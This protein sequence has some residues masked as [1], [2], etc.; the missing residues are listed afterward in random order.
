MDG[1][2]MGV[3]VGWGGVAGYT[4]P[5][6]KREASG[7]AQSSSEP[8]LCPST[9]IIFEQESLWQEQVSSLSSVGRTVQGFSR[10]Y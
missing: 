5:A 9:N 1:L 4:E 10:M 3:G 6:C 8:L 7:P 2:W